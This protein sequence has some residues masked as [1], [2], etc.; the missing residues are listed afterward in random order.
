M[1]ML[2]SAHPVRITAISWGLVISSGY[3]IGK[4]AGGFWGA[5]YTGTGIGVTLGSM[6]GG[7]LTTFILQSKF[8]VRKAHYLISAIGWL[9]AMLMALLI[10]S[11]I[12]QALAD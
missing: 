3:L 8:Q 2:I 4:T 5:E 6:A 9:I 1:L 11:F 12:G 10:I 7:L